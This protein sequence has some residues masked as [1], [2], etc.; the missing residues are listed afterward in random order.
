MRKF[1]SKMRL[2]YPC[3][4]HFIPVSDPI[5]DRAKT[6]PPMAQWE[7]RKS[8]ECRVARKHLVRILTCLRHA[9]IFQG[10]IVSCGAEHP[11]R[12]LVSSA[13][14]HPAGTRLCCPSLATLHACHLGRSG[15]AAPVSS[16][17][18][19][20]VCIELVDCENRPITPT[21]KP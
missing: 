12:K 3:Y 7:P 16:P 10:Q 13:T 18:P 11:N 20:R 4:V 1:S 21:D 5:F 9:W 14:R 15:C 17:S 8:M 6:C 19:G 2:K